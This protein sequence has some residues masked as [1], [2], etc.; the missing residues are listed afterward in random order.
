MKIVRS[1]GT[2]ALGR[3]GDREGLSLSL[4][5]ILL[6]ILYFMEVNVWSYI[7]MQLKV[8]VHMDRMILYF[9]CH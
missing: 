2:I 5:L 1:T 6:Y 8:G 3:R 7:E 9:P 4:F